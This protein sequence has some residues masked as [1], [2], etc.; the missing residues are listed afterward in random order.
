MKT[1]FKVD[2]AIQGQNYIW[3]ALNKVKIKLVMNEISLI[4]QLANYCNI[5][6][7]RYATVGTSI[8]IGR[9]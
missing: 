2:V 8:T 7:N 4:Q 1:D 6:L 3:C 5:A 9:F